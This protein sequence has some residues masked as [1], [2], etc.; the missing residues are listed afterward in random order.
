VGGAA[1]NLEPADGQGAA[2]GLGGGD[3]LGVRGGRVG[4]GV[5]VLVLRNVDHLHLP[6]PRPHRSPRA[7]P[8]AIELR[9]RSEGL[10][11]GWH[12][13]GGRMGPVC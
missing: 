10:V 6:P 5:H 3:E 13:F 11:G 12:G 4:S 8:S 9:L 1:G 7:T 2:L